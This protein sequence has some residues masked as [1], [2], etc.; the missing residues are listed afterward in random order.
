[1]KILIVMGGFFPGKKFGGPP[2]S[3]NNFCSLMEE[4]D[5]YIVTRNHDMGSKEIYSD[6]NNGWN[7]RINCKVLYLDDKEYR[8]KKFK[9]VIEEINPNIIYLQGLFQSCIIPCLILAKRYKIPLILA[10]RGELCEGAMKKKYKKIPYIIFLRIFRLLDNIS[11]QSTSKDETDAIRRWLKVRTDRIDLLTNIPSIPLYDKSKT[12][13][14]QG[15]ANFIFLSRIVSKKNLLAV[16]E[17]MFHVSGNVRL[18]IY[19][20]IEDKEYWNKCKKKINMLPDNI[21]V[22]YKGIVNHD[23]VHDTFKKYDAF[24][25]PTFSE[26]FGHVIVEAL[27]VGCPVIISDQTPWSD[28]ANVDGGWSIPIEKEEKYIQAIQEIIDADKEK[29]DTYKD[30]IRT[31]VHKKINISDINKEY[32]NLFQKLIMEKV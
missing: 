21:N 19:G 20:T 14:K 10:P 26:N 18:D 31:Y 5:C 7:E 22:E 23:Q 15:E 8:Y 3:V 32:D 12:Y 4:Y 17:Y 27:M 2:V 24:I 25:F 13:K 30:N 16:I 9:E 1:M 11:F 28:V 29:E 6:I